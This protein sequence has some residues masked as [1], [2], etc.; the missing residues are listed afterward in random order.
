[1]KIYPECK[2]ETAKINKKCFFGFHR[3]S[4]PFFSQYTT[5]F[6]ILVHF[7]LIA[8]TQTFLTLLSP[9]DVIC[10]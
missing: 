3:N 1:M 2:L 8:T 4:I 6:M 9:I 5:G 7:Y 10:S